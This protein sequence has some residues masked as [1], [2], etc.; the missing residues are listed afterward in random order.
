MQKGYNG[1]LR[2]PS[3]VGGI[4][5]ARVE[6]NKDPLKLGRVQVR[7][8]MFHG[9]GLEDGIS[10]DSLPWAV[11]CSNNGAGYNYGS[12]IVPEIGEYVMVMF[13]D[14][15]PD[16]PVYIG[17]VY[18]SGS[19]VQ[20][21]YG[22]KEVKTWNGTVGANEVPIESQRDFPT[23]KMLY[24]S[25]F[26]SKIY[27]DTA[28]ETESI[29]AEDAIGQ[30]YIISSNSKG[31]FI[32]M[33]GTE[34]MLVHIEGGTVHVGKRGGPGVTITPGSENILINAGSSSM[35]YN[36]SNITIQTGHLSIDAGSGVTIHSGGSTWSLG[37]GGVSLNT[38]SYN[39]NA[40]SIYMRGS[41]VT[42]VEG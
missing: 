3:D 7:I 39:V 42:I 31:T 37:G 26:G 16:K 8:P 38:G 24:K 19:T 21:K 34:Q 29:V 11:F 32:E 5:R 25:P 27:M 9:M 1:E 23:H 17:S 35:S 22:S 36:G 28:E 12:F 15:D 18:G 10:N 2:N 13:E 14:N 40:D 4:Y 20:K 30:K 41:S 33:L 6:N